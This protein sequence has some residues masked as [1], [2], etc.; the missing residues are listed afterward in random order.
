MPRYYVKY[1]EKK[2]ALVSGA[3]TAQLGTLEYYRN[4]ES[5]D[6]RRDKNAG[7]RTRG[8][9]GAVF[10]GMD[11]PPTMD[12]RTAQRVLGLP[13]EISDFGIA[14]RPAKHPNC[15]VFSVSRCDD[16]H[17]PSREEAKSICLD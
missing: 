14:T 10:G 3:G 11:N 13:M 7:V 1:C 5:R 2:H 17:P 4:M 15:Y 12:V 6:G 16:A 8:V 9:R